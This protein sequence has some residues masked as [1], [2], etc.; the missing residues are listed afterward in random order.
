MKNIKT[1]GAVRKKKCMEA[2]WCHH[3]II[4]HSVANC[5]ILIGFH[6]TL[7]IHA[8]NFLFIHEALLDCNHS[9]LE[10]T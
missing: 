4:F 9:K 2:H 8:E 6:H 10:M 1:T 5:L 7:F 3:N